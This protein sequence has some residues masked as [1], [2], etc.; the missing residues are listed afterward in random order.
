MQG[1]RIALGI[2]F[3]LTATFL[4]MASLVA[5]AGVVA[6]RNQLQMAE[7]A[8]VKEA[9]AVATTVSHPIVELFW[10]DTKALQTYV[11]E[12]NQRQHRDISVIDRKRMIMADVV[13]AEIGGLVE[14]DRLNGEVGWLWI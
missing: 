12:L 8:A 5:V 1:R 9:V 6:I 11:M 4:V 14:A 10:K 13:P 3:K 7:V 2:R